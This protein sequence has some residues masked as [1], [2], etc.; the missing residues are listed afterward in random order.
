MSLKGPTS[1]QHDGSGLRIAIVHARWNLCVIEPL[2]A[3]TKK[4]LL[5]RGVKETNIVVQS[6]PGAWELPLAVQ[7]YAFKH[8]RVHG[9]QQNPNSDGLPVLN[10]KKSLFSASQVQSSAAGG[11]P[12]AGD[13][14]VSSTT[15]LAALA[16]GAPAASSTSSSSLSGAFDAIVAIGVLIKGET[17]HFEY[18]ADSV[19]HGL[20]RV[21]LD[22]SVPVVFGVL[23]VLDEQQAKARAGLDSKGH[24]HGED[25]GLAAVEM[26]VKRRE[27]AAG[28]MEG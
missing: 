12:S 10:P 5:A 27:W 1:E 11:G 2:V 16:T 13:L 3:G 25:W 26:G 20:M 4:Q 7:R 18:I 17:M 15:D 14:L 6:C 8:K 23:T 19:S 28:K 21:Q 22:T 9:N 24:N